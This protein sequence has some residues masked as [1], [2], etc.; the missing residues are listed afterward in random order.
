[1]LRIGTLFR[2]IGAFEHALDQLNIKHSIQFACDCGERELPLK[3]SDLR[4]LVR[5]MSLVEIKSFCKNYI[6]NIGVR[7]E[8]RDIETDLLVQ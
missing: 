6:G 7:R 3:Y 1:M 2:G 8:F 5:D 4:Q